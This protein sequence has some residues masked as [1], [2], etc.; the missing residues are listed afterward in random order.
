[1][2]IAPPISTKPDAQLISL[3]G[4]LPP[5]LSRTRAEQTRDLFMHMEGKLCEK[6]LTFAN[7]VR[8]WFHLDSIL[9]WYDEFNSV[10]STFF[11]ERNVSAGIIPASTGVGM[12]NPRGAAI[13]GSVLALKPGSAQAKA[14][15][16]PL[17]C[18][19]LDY[20]SAFSRAV[21]VQTSEQRRLY[22]SGTASI[23]AKGATVFLD[24]VD[25]QIEWT[26]AVVDALL[27]SRNMTWNEHVTR[28]IA[29]FPTLSDAPRM[30]AYCKARGLN[31]ASISF[32]E[33]TICR[34]DLLFEIEVDGIAAP[35]PRL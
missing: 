9:E 17:Q 27:Q 12:R 35:D 19:A 15:P 8:T 10:R 26:M 24:D 3:T 21:E 23:D 33:A 4:L 14:L 25:G 20:H 7:V 11:R 28:A 34:G 18:P 1:M 6:G 32:A 13:A 31:T 2:I 5:D 22:I 30:N 29:Y 16:S